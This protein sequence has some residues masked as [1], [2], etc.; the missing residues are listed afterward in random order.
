MYQL[1][2][3][4]PG[5]PGHYKTSN[6]RLASR[7]NEHWSAAISH[8][9]NVVA[10]LDGAVIMKHEDGVTYKATEVIPFKA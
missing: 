6:H 8:G 2:I 5:R 7:A 3:E 10:V 1:K 4:I 9:L